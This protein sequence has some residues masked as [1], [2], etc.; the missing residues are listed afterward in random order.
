MNYIC[1][2]VVHREMMDR[3]FTVFIAVIVVIDWT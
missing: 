3:G 2:K 1:G